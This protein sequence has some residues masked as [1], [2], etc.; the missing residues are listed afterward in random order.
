M[1]RC[2]TGSRMLNSFLQF[3]MS[4]EKFFLLTQDLKLLGELSMEIQELVI[5]FEVGIAFRC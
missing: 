2:E 1:Q 3:L 5:A 4:H